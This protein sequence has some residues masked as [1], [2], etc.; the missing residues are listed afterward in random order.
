MS[1]VKVSLLIPILTVAHMRGPNI[2]RSFAGASGGLAKSLVPGFFYKAV[3]K[4][5]GSCLVDSAGGAP[6]SNS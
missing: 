4:L 2:R 6:P 5:H 1:T 3:L